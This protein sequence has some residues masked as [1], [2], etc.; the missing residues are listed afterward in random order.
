VPPLETV[1]ELAVVPDVIAKIMPLVT[2]TPV[3][4]DSR[5]SYR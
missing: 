1:V 2:A 3:L 4:K 5:R